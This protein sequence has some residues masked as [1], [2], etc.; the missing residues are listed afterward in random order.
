MLLVLL[1]VSIESRGKPFFRQ[2]RIGYEG[3]PFTIVKFETFRVHPTEFSR[4][5]EIKSNDPRLT[6][7]GGLIRRLKLDE[8]PQVLNVLRGEM[9]VVGPRPDIPEQAIDYDEFARG[10]LNVR[11]G[12]TGVVQ[13]SGNTALK[14]NERFILDA[15]YVKNQSN[16]LDI[17]IIALTLMSIIR[18]DTRDNDPLQLHRLLNLDRG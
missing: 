1:V 14:W 2:T 4:S 17:V 12:L 3:K 11:P 10:R 7:L 18:G 8:L 9:S 6:A 13:V 15:W 5:E 16:R